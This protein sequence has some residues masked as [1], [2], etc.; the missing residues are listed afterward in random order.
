MKSETTFLHYLMKPKNWWVPIGIIFLVSIIGLGFIAYQTY[1]EAPPIP[2]FV[3]ENGNKV[4]SEAE[5]LKGQEVFH[6]YA[7]MEYGSMFGDGALRGPDFTAQALNVHAKA[8]KEYYIKNLPNYQGLQ[9]LGEAAVTGKVQQEIKANTYQPS[10]NSAVLNSA[11]IAGVRAVEDFYVR[12]F[13]DAGFGE[14]FNP[15]GYI[16]N[17]EEIRNLARF[18]YWGAWVCSVQRPGEKYSYTHNWPYDPEAGNVPT[19]ST[20]IWSIVGLLGLVLGL[21]IVMYYYGQ[22]EQLNQEYYSKGA[23]EMVTEEKLHAF[24]PSPTQRATFKFFYVAILLFLVQ[25][26]AGVL[27]VHDFVGFTNFFGVDLQEAIP[28][29]ISRSW[30][31]QLSLYWISACWVGI[32]FFVLPLLAKK[33]PKGQLLLINLLFG[34]FFVM[35]A[36]SFVGIF[37]G[38]KGMLGSYSRWLG[39]QGW[40]FVELGR[41]YQYFLLA[42][43]ALWALIVYRG[44]KN[45]FRP[46]MPWALPNWL[47]YSIVCILILLMSG[48]VARPET[49]F[50]IADFWR[51]MVV[52]MWVEAFFEV[53][54]TIIVGYMMVMM[55]LVNRQAVVKVVYLAALLFLGSGLLGISHN[56]YWN[57]KPVGT[58]ALGSVFSTLQVVPLILLTLEAWKMQK[59]PHLL[60]DKS[61]GRGRSSLFAMPGVFLYILGVTFWNFFGAGVFGLIINLPIANYYEHGTYLTVN[62]GHA[63]LMGVYG[64][65]SIAALLFCLRYLIQPEAWNHQ[66]IKASF[67]SINLGLLLM[68]VLDLFP[69]GIHQLVTVMEEGYW[70]A[71]SQEFIQGTEF[72][73]MT[74]LRIV[75]G[76][77]FCVGGL[78]PLTWFV[79]RSAR[80]V[81]KQGPLNLSEIEKNEEEVVEVV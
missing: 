64:N 59:M 74:W 13:T 78:F 37:L 51:W 34:I 73:S 4:M 41:L 24:T 81:K 79:L 40:E 56:F 28:V 17:E 66:L 76:S 2:D 58:L 62:H 14:A 77:I 36:G 29:T 48:F 18:F 65:L 63:A 26:L 16:Q 8:M 61:N 60:E 47:V 46:G 30:H 12:V 31:V 38:P 72:Q 35:V 15:T 21:G 53:F 67:W 42:I 54:T 25:V 55:G 9:E 32:S 6:R 70:Y 11:Q 10:D 22:F 52:H 75:G 69:A 33:E 39:H 5:I 80:Y 19:P 1:E 71:R 27:T 7:L 3:D 45:T 20:M 49:N 50:V 23:S 68:V 57:A 43:F 44:V